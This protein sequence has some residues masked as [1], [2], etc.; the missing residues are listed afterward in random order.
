MHEYLLSSVRF[1]REMGGLLE[2][3][4]K[5]WIEVPVHEEINTPASH[6]KRISLDKRNR[7]FYA[8]ARADEHNI[9]ATCG[10]CRCSG[11]RILLGSGEY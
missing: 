4:S 2:I 8:S 10:L 11:L 3:L 9:A 1:A 5:R 7:W 6:Y